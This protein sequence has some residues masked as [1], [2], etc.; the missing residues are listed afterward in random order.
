MCAVALVRADKTATPRNPGVA[1]AHVRRFA[2][3]G[4]PLARRSWMCTSTSRW[5]VGV[6]RCCSTSWVRGSHGVVMMSVYDLQDELD[7]SEYFRSSPG[8]AAAVYH[9]TGVVT[10]HGRTVNSGHYTA[11]AR[12]VDGVSVW[13][14][15][16]LPA[17]G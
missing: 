17:P 11:F 13:W 16:R 4:P 12:D 7:L 1:F 5:C 15:A 2:Q 14:L 6:G 9:L 3:H 10:H 8:D